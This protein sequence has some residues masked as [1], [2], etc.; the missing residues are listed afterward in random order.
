MIRYLLAIFTSGTP[1]KS[2]VYIN[3][4]SVGRGYVMIILID[5]ILDFIC[6]LAFFLIL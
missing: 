1:Q 6:P 5:L 3:D 4:P 2:S